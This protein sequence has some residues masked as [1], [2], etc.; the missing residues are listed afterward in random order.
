MERR[1]L[2]PDIGFARG[3]LEYMYSQPVKYLLA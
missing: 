3:D 2:G 1:G